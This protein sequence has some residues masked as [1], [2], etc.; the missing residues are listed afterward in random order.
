MSE[1]I[2]LRLGD[3][4]E[5]MQT[6]ADKSVDLILC[7]LPYGTTACKWDSV[8]P[9]EPLWAE[10]RRVIKEN[11]AIVLTAA[12]PFTSALVMSNPEMF[13]YELIWEKSKAIGFLYAKKRPMACHENI[14]VFSRGWTTYNP[15]KQPGEPYCRG[16]RKESTVEVLRNGATIKPSFVES[17]DGSRYPRSVHKA[18]NAEFDGKFHPTQKPVAL[19]EYLIRTYTNEGDTVLDNCMGSG[20]TGVASVNTGRKFVGIERD[21][22]YFA[23]ATNRIAEAARSD[24]LSAA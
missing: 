3:C 2:D 18:K 17:K 16:M 7:D 20:T 15:Q 6:I 14:L 24:L 12:Q 10:Y 23:I 13:R 22:T 1:K 9:F 5:V 11:G 8:I 19:M 21:P 4:L